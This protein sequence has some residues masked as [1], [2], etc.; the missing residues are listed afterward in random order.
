MC[1]SIL[2]ASL[3]KTLDKKIQT[4]FLKFRLSTLEVLSVLTQFLI[5]KLV[6]KLNLQTLS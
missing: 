5:N 2:K 6:D 3:I 4:I 1:Y